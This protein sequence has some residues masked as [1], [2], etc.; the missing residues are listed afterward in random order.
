VFGEIPPDTHDLL[1]L[2]SANDD[3]LFRFDPDSG[4]WVYNLGTKLF[5]ATGTYTVMVTSGENGEYIISFPDG[6]CTQTF[7][8]LP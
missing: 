4:Q 7:E 6:N 2:G 5:T 3:N 1:P 8:R